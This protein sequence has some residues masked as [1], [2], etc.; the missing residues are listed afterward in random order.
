[1]RPAA[2]DATAPEYDRHRALPE[3]VAASIRSAV[4]ALAG[5]GSKPSVLDLGAGT[6]RIGWPFVA[7][8][9]DYV[10][11]DVSF[12]MLR[13]F[14]RRTD[15]DPRLA[16]CEGESLPFRDGA[17]DVVMLIQVIGGARGWR[18]LVAEARRV[19]HG[20]GSLVIGKTV[21]PTDGIDA[22]LKARLAE[23]LEELGVQADEKQAGK[24]LG[25]LESVAREK[26]VVVAASWIS[27]RSP[28]GFLDRK[29]TGAKF[30]ELPLAVREEALRRLADWAT[31]TYGSLERVRPESY[32]FEL[33]TFSFSGD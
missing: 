1:M 10:G 14:I 3:D 23:I 5:E 16:C 6:G 4:L 32:S 25:W 27:E 22:R 33:T 19:L 17:F 24:A 18:R 9:D 2:F 30:L 15:A 21:S 31:A 8:D 28:R 29:P 26:R 12:G 13:E 20:N 7:A 11:V